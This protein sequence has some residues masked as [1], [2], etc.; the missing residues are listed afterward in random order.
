MTFLVETD[1]FTRE[2]AQ[3]KRDRVVEPHQLLCPVL[4]FC[5]LFQLFSFQPLLK[6]INLKKGYLIGFSLLSYLEE[7]LAPIIPNAFT[8]TRRSAPRLN[9]LIA[10]VYHHLAEFFR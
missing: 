9:F 7:Y 5:S 6:K 2:P 4:G 10:L 3:C 8:L 1:H